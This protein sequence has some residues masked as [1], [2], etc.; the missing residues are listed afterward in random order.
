MRGVVGC[1]SYSIFSRW[2]WRYQINISSN[3]LLRISIYLNF[4]K[5]HGF[6]ISFPSFVSL[7]LGDLP[8]NFWLELME[9]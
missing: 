3:Y 6:M 4:P 9:G 7:S 5:V 8:C 1:K 2:K